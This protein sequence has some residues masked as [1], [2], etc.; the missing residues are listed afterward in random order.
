[1]KAKITEFPKDVSFM[2]FHPEAY[3]ELSNG[4]TCCGDVLCSKQMIYSEHH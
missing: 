2:N 1:M 3:L 4:S